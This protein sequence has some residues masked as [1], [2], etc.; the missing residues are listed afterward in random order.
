MQKKRLK[1][2]FQTCFK[3][4]LKVYYLLIHIVNKNFITYEVISKVIQNKDK[5]QNHS[6]G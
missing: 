6:T 3:G 1:K 2:C 5:E 4:V